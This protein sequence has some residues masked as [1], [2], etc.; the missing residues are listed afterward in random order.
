[1]SEPPTPNYE[2]LFAVKLSPIKKYG[3]PKRFVCSPNSLKVNIDL[4]SSDIDFGKI[5]W[6]K[7]DSSNDYRTESSSYRRKWF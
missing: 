1:M 3:N 6:L 4:D 2:I 7:S 5:N